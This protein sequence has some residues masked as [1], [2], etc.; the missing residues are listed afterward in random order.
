MV[1][2]RKCS[3]EII[4]TDSQ[5]SANGVRIKLNTYQFYPDTIDLKYIS[6]YMYINEKGEIIAQETA[7]P[8]DKEKLFSE[9]ASYLK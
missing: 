5:I 1:P 4:A 6:R 2:H 7:R 8:S 9:I 3:E